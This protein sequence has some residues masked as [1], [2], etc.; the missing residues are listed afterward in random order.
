MEKN[1]NK[2]QGNWT[3]E[4]DLVSTRP[5]YRIRQENLIHNEVS[6]SNAGKFFFGFVLGSLFDTK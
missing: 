5:D 6:G 2:K 3:M 1:Q 4:F